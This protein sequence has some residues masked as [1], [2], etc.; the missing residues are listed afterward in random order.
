MTLR[1]VRDALRRGTPALLGATA[2]L[3]A[4]AASAQGAW[5]A[6]ETLPQSAGRYPLFAA[7][8]PQ[9]AAHVGLFGPTLPGSP[10]APLA[11]ATAPGDAAFGVPAGL[12]D[13]LGTVSPG[14]TLLAVGGLP[15]SLDH[16]GGE[17]RR[18]L[19]RV[20]IGPLG[21]RL[22]R[23]STTRGIAGT[24][25]LAGAVNDS[26][27]AAVVFSRCVD[28]TC[29]TRTV[30]ATFRR[31]GR[32]FGAP[33]VL[34]RRTGFPV[35]AVTINPRGD[36][37]VAWIEHRARRRGND[38][39]TRMRRAD[40]TLTK[41]RLAGS[42]APA[43]AI[44]VTL[45]PGRH[46]VVSWFSQPVAGGSVGGPP[47][48]STVALNSHGNM[49]G[50]KPLD[51]GTAWRRPTAPARGARLRAVLGP[52]G[53]TTFAWTGFAGGHYVVRAERLYRDIGDQESLSP[54]GID[55][56]LMDLTTDAAGDVLAV[57]ATAPDTAPVPGVA[58]VIRPAGA[59]P[60]A[61]S[62]GAP[63]LVLTG[64]DASGTAAGAIAP[65]GRALVAGGPE[66]V[67]GRIASQG[68]RVTRLADRCRRTAHD[69][70]SGALTSS[71]PAA[72]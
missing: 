52:D 62:F 66:Q 68:V 30:L 7:F 24:R 39:R 28:A 63:Q 4:L 3:G 10:N 13:G 57:W 35:A 9:G 56:Q 47:T 53:S 15:T 8:G 34:A 19:L 65:G 40:G 6:P 64:A 51:P 46:G 25:T 23:I 2:A 20:A 29:A 11:V 54:P 26:G 48:V 43:P 44:A 32:S 37:L 49:G 22:Q 67:L 16:V 18:S 5:T 70:G 42:S 36:A 33:V 45:T 71:E 60:G 31:R 17:P 41:V 55:A 58:A 69:A 21:G 50:L 27:D 12:R 38:I 14:G 1:S 59:P 72:G 61:P